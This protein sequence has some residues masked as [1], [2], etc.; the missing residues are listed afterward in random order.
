MKTC[1]KCKREKEFDDFPINKTRKD[2]Y[3]NVCKTCQSEYTKAHYHNN[4]KQYFNRN[5]RRRKEAREYV[6]NYKKT[7]ACKCGENRWWVLDFHHI[8]KKRENISSLLAHGV[9]TVK[10]EIEKCEIVCANCHRDLHFQRKYAPVAQLDN[11]SHYECEDL[12]VRI[13]SGV[14][15]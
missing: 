1:S 15:I 11:A 7:H 14:L 5:K 13:P 12:G 2:G 6:I 9:E 8:D 4:K 3:G 10:N